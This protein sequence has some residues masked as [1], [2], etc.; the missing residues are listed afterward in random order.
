MKRHSPTSS[1]AVEESENHIATS[2]MDL[3]RGTNLI[4]LFNVKK[5]ALLSSFAKF[6]MNGSGWVLNKNIKFIVKIYRYT[7]LQNG[8]VE[9]QAPLNINDDDV[10]GAYFD[11]GNPEIILLFIKNPKGKG[12]WCV[13]PNLPSLSCLVSSGVSK[14]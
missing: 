13:I 10:G 14:S 4:E 6:E 9:P 12:H 2:K 8:N 1:V 3:F 7:P 5:A 11:I